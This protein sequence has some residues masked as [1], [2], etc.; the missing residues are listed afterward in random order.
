PFHNKIVLCAITDTINLH[1]RQRPYG[2]HYVAADEH[3]NVRVIIE[4]FQTRE[5]DLNAKQD[6]LSFHRPIWKNVTPPHADDVSVHVVEASGDYV[7]TAKALLA[8]AQ[9]LATDKHTR[10][11]LE[12]HV[13]ENNHTARGLWAALKTVSIEHSQIDVRLKSG[14]AYVALSYQDADAD[15]GSEFAWR[16]GT[17]ALISGGLGALGLL[18]ARDIAERT[19]GSILILL[20]R[21]TPNEAETARIEALRALGANVIHRRCD[22]ARLDEVEKIVAEHPGIDVVVH[23]AGLIDDALVI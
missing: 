5:I 1:I 3:G 9:S 7:A 4:G 21:R 14:D 2:M 12:L 22:I 19:T 8:A 15:I 11:A 23:A 18:V 20:G 10:S 6:R 16:N 13:V 17:T